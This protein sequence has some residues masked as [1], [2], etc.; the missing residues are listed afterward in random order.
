[1]TVEIDDKLFEALSGEITPKFLATASA[2]G[3]PNIVPVISIEPW[4]KH[5]LIF[6]DLMIWKTKNNLMEQPRVGVGVLTTDMKCWTL[7]GVFE[8]F[9][10]TGERYDQVGMRE[11]FRYNA[12]SGLRGCGSIRVEDAR[13]IRGLISPARI[14]EMAFAS[15]DSLGVKFDHTGP[16]PPQVT[17]KFSRSKA[18]K[19]ISFIDTDGYPVA[20]PALTMFPAGHDVLEIGAGALKYPDGVAPAVPFRAAAAIITSD[21]IAYQIKGTVTGFVNRLGVKLARLEVDKAFAAS[22]PIPGKLISAAG[23]TT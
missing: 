11:L 3:E 14:A 10:R 6:G 7:K 20:L 4:D 1:M 22:P 21:P 17:E 13:R 2:D 8:G 16:M 18:A 5:T 15:I 19:F 23:T 12:Y 9:E